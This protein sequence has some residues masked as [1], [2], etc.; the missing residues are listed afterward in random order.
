VAVIQAENVV[1]FVNDTLRD[2]GKPKFTDI[3]SNLQRHVGMRNLL[4]KNRAVLESGSGIQFN[5]LVAQSNAARNVSLGESDN[6][7]QFDGMVQANTVWRHS[8]T[9]YMLIHQLMSMNREPA[10]I[11]DFV[12]QQ[13]L[14]AMISLAELMESN[15]WAAPS[16]TDQKTPLGIPYWITKNAT[17]GF[18]GGTLTGY[19][20]VAGLNTT[21][22]PAWNNWTAPYTSVSRD[23]F[24]R[25]AREAATKVDFQPSVDGIPSPN[26]GDSFGFYTTYAVVQPL[27][28]TLESQNDNLGKDIASQDG[29]VLFRR[30][31]VTW[32]PWLDRDTTNPFYGINWGWFKTHILRGEWMRETN[33]PYTPGQHN[34]A[35]HFIDLTYNWVCKNRR[36][37]FV[38]SN[39]VTYPS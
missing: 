30:V 5:V 23:D 11:V 9:S 27:E 18:N 17:K 20:N 28:E 34:V 37:N 12:L 1:D 16:V 10:R 38:L 25:Q 6:V 8:Q 13:R 31:P 35:S 33:I 14:M 3:S 26:T 32:V 2:L 22:Y 15:L 29:K 39:G 4:Q 21:T 36:E 24:I 19:S 7:N